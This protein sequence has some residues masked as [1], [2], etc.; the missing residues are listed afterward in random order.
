MSGVFSSSSMTSQVM[1]GSD[2]RESDISREEQVKSVD[3]HKRKRTGQCIVYSKPNQMIPMFSHEL[4]PEKV[5]D[6]W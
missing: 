3:G 6:K 4:H 1:E 5:V 2:R